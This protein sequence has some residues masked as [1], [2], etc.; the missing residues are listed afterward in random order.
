MAPIN[1]ITI[2]AVKAMPK[3]NIKGAVDDIAEAVTSATKSTG[4]PSI[5]IKSVSKP[6]KITIKTPAQQTFEEG[7]GANILAEQNRA[8]VTRPIRINSRGGG[9]ISPYANDYNR[10]C[11]SGNW[12]YQ[13]T[14]E[15]A[16][17]LQQKFFNET[18]LILHIPSSSTGRFD[19]ALNSICS[20]VNKGTF[21][22]DIKHVLIGHGSGSSQAKTWFL[23]GQGLRDGKTVEIFP[24]INA[25][26][27]KGEK[28]LVTSCES[29]CGK[30]FG[31]P[32]IG[33]EVQLSLACIES[34]GKVV[35]SGT[36]RIIGHYTTQE[37]FKPY[38]IYIKPNI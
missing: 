30:V 23:E 16:A 11:N 10:L 6:N 31:K 1:P 32:G 38:E 4:K 26:I 14:P 5:D 12:A 24:Y 28:V 3:I 21:P 13:M 36:D 15:K 22:K 18:G 9:Y 35:R 29:P 33:D 2:K 7:V 27:P 20:E 37:G 25:N 8:M 34:P 19:I 17:E